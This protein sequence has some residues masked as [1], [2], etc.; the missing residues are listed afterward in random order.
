[1]ENQLSLTLEEK[2]ALEKKLSGLHKNGPKLQTIQK[3]TDTLIPR[4]I[5][6]LEKELTPLRVLNETL[7]GTGKT[8][9][10]YSYGCKVLE[11]SL[12]LKNIF[13]LLNTDNFFSCLKI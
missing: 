6:F 1:M 13:P 5:D 7:E 2:L 10:K 12:E 8:S 9:I 11:V 3:D 4:E